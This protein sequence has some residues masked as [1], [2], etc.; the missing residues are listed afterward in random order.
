MNDFEWRAAT[1]PSHMISWLYKQG[2]RDELWDFTVANCRR[3]LPELPEDPFRFVIHQVENIGVRD[4][5]DV[6]GDVRAALEKLERRLHKTTS[7][8]KQDRLNRQIGFGRMF[9]AFDYQSV[10]EMAHSISSD[11]IEWAD[12][13]AEE[14]KRQSDLLRDL[15]PVASVAVTQDES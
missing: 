9:L 15:V 2:Y 1:D 6:L 12:D 7:S 5:E 10:D 13:E 11:L 8:K 3:A 14:R 4:I